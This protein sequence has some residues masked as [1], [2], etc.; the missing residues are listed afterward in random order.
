MKKIIAA[1][2]AAAALV[3]PALG[4]TFGDMPGRALIMLQKAC[5]ERPQHC[6]EL[7]TLVL[8][9]FRTWLAHGKSKIGWD[10]N[11]FTFIEEAN[12]RLDDPKV[13]AA[14]RRFFASRQPSA[15]DQQ[16]AYGSRSDATI[17]RIA[18]DNV[19]G[20]C[21]HIDGYVGPGWCN[22]SN[23]DLAAL[24][25]ASGL[26]KPE[27]TDRIGWGQPSPD[28][29]RKETTALSDGDRIHNAHVR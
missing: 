19:V 17:Q 28:A 13:L 23:D 25:Q 2:Y 15:A 3:T 14:V 27:E 26:L 1:L 9:D 22:G 8:D 16:L 20:W 24:A 21:R 29:L 6:Y 10:K 11:D 12:K 5:Q 7:E 4:Q 18:R